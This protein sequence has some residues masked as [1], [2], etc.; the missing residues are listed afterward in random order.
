MMVEQSKKSERVSMENAG[1]ADGKPYMRFELP[2]IS[3][4]G[5]T[6]AISLFQIDYNNYADR[7]LAGSSS[8]LDA[9]KN[10]MIS[11]AKLCTSVNGLLNLREAIEEILALTGVRLPPLS[12][13]KE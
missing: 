10:E 9:S 13:K 1:F 2:K 4:V 8:S 3:K 6:Y 12:F 5:D 11:A 7:G